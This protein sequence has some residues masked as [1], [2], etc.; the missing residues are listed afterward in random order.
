MYAPGDNVSL[1]IMVVDADSAG[2]GV[3]K[4]GS[5]LCAIV[6]ALA[7]HI[8]F[9]LSTPWNRLT[10]MHRLSFL[11]GCGDDWIEV[12]LIPPRPPLVREVAGDSS[13]PQASACAD[14]P[15]GL[16]P[17][18]RTLRFKWHGFFPAISRATRSSWQ[19]RKRLEDLVTEVPCDA[20]TGG[21]LRPDLAEQL[22]VQ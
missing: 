17:A 6:S 14:P 12:A 5:K 13:E 21:R 3:L 11:H 4:P 9:A 19:Y 1:N 16:K 22:P 15:R 20:C 10:E 7:D 18:A 2:W 8:G